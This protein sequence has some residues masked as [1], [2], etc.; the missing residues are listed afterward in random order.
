M[1]NLLLKTVNTIPD[2]ELTEIVF[3]LTTM[4]FYLEPQ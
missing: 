3:A 4:L 1:L 2:M